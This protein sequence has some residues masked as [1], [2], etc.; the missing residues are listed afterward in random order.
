MRAAA[1]AAAVLDV[2]AA[3]QDVAA[4]AALADRC[5]DVLAVLV[6]QVL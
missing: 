2:A 3:I 1:A 5:V 4:A 6:L